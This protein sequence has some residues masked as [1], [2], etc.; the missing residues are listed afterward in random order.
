MSD[1]EDE[2]D[3]L[4]H[5][6]HQ[7]MDRAP[8]RRWSAIAASDIL[9][10]GWKEGEPFFS[11][12]LVALPPEQSRVTPVRSRHRSRTIESWFPPLANFID[13]KNEDEPPNWRSFIE[14]STATT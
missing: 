13:L 7:S 9:S 11:D 5:S 4:A 12:L 2:D 6:R 14:F 8:S 3:S 10:S 1:D